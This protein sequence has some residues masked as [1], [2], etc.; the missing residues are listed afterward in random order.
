VFIIQVLVTGCAGFIG[1]HP[2]DRLLE[3]GFEVVGIDCFTGY[4]PRKIKE[5]NIRNALRLENFKL[6]RKDILGVVEK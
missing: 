4:Y 2:T 5:R 1:Y 6:I 3:E